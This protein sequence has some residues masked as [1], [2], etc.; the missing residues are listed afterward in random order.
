MD[1]ELKILLLNK[2]ASIFESYG[3]HSLTVGDNGY[4][5]TYHVHESKWQPLVTDD[6]EPLHN[7]IDKLKYDI[8]HD[9]VFYAFAQYYSMKEMITIRAKISK[10]TEW[11]ECRKSVHSLI[12]KT[13]GGKTYYEIFSFPKDKKIMD[14][15]LS[16]KIPVMYAKQKIENYELPE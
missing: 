6:D 16:S 1:D 2:Y 14:E 3:L 13:E 8:Q 12:L 4:I 10:E 11:E 5:V 9:C 7:L 15:L